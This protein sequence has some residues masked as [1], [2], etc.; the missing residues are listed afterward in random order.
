MDIFYAPADKT[1][2]LATLHRNEERVIEI[3]TMVAGTRYAKAI[4]LHEC[5]HHY[6]GDWTHGERFQN[7]MLRLAILGAFRGVW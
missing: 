5:N 7:G 4:L 2:G 3:D 1:H 6:T